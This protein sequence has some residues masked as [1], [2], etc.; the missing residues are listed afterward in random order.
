MNDTRTRLVVFLLG[1]P[2]ILESAERSQDGTTNPD[3][4]FP[5]R[6]SDNL[7]L[8]AGWRQGGQLLLH[9]IGDTWEHRGSSGEDD[10]S[11]QVTTDIQIA[12]EDRVVPGEVMRFVTR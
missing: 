4:I 9:A 6:R 5:F 1:T 10:I 12:L 11:V 2:E 8:H 7:D 3:R